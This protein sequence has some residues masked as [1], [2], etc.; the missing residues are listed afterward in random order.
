MTQSAQ[1]LEIR[2]AE[3]RRQLHDSVSQLKEAVREKLDV[4]SHAR[5]HF[6]P[7]TGVVSVVGLALGYGL[8]SLMLRKR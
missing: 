1:V 3:Q 8:A 2:A 4:K 7:A 5:E 6:L